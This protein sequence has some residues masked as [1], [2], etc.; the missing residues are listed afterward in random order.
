MD[1]KIC[2]ICKS[3]IRGDVFSLSFEVI[4]GEDRTR[5]RSTY[6]HVCG[7]CKTMI[8]KHI[9]GLVKTGVT[10]QVA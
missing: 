5:T 8:G 3:V 4:E 2:D 10:I 6:N 9:E 7:N 1:L